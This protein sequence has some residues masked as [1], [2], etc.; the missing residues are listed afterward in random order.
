MIQAG[1]PVTTGADWCV[2]WQA[3]RAPDT[4]ELPR[5]LFDFFLQQIDKYA[6]ASMLTA[7]ADFS[8]VLSLRGSF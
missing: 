1:I 8:R 3:A 6:G 7:D 4:F 5:P 2:N